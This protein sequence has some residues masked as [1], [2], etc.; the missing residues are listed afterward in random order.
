MLHYRIFLL[1]YFFVCINLFSQG[2]RKSSCK[3]KPDIVELNSIT[4][5]SVTT[6]KENTK[7]KEIKI[8]YNRRIRKKKVVRREDASSIN[9][10]NKIGIA[11]NFSNN[12]IMNEK[13]KNITGQQVLFSVADKIPLFEKCTSQEIKDK[14]ECFNIEMAKH[15]EKHFHPEDIIDEATSNRIFIQFI[16]DY[17]GGVKNIAIKAKKKSKVLE[18]EI[19]R[20]IYKL[21][22]FTPG[23]HNNI[24][25]NVLYSLPINLNME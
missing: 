9:T 19:S 23:T 8:T 10:I 20:V 11:N 6:K 3:S 15:F 24:P 13:L 25:V 17:K 21:N 18:K 2:S 12:K 7:T 14:R 16:I 22:A 5:C 1:L 4:K